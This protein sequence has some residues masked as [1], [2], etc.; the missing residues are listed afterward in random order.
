[1]G[2]MKNLISKIK[3]KY[4]F[5]ILVLIFCNCSSIKIEDDY[6]TVKCNKIKSIDDSLA[7]IILESKQDYFDYFQIEPNLMV[8]LYNST[9]NKVYIDCYNKY[10]WSDKDLFIEINLKKIQYEAFF[11]SENTLIIFQKSPS[12][13]PY[14]LKSNQ[15][16]KIP[17]YF[18]ESYSV[19]TYSYLLDGKDHIFKLIDKFEWGKF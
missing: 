17:M 19:I 12:K 15:K 16:V 5:P 11:Y 10:L 18:D 2:D 8:I 1:M 7:S 4:Y 6:Y 14:I 9:Q 13:N 3:V